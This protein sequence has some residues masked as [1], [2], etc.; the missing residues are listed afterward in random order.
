[1]WKEL[2]LP[3][4][5]SWSLKWDDS[6][7]VNQRARLPNEVKTNREICRSVEN[8]HTLYYMATPDENQID[9]YAYENGMSKVLLKGYSGG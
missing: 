8:V 6:V 3:D 4:S 2:G 1:M 5:A 7:H 9:S